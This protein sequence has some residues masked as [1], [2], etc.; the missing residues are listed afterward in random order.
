MAFGSI[1]YNTDLWLETESLPYLHEYYKAKLANLPYILRAAEH[2]TPIRSNK[3]PPSPLPPHAHTK[4]LR[5]DAISRLWSAIWDSAPASF[6][7]FSAWSFILHYLLTGASEKNKEETLQRGQDNV[8]GWVIGKTGFAH[9]RWGRNEFT[10]RHRCP[11][12]GL[13][14]H[15]KSV[16]CL[17]CAWGL[18]CTAAR[19]GT[20]A[21]WGGWEEIAAQV[22]SWKGSGPHSA[23]E[24][25]EQPGA[26]WQCCIMRS[27]VLLYSHHWFLYPTANSHAEES[28][29]SSDPQAL[30]KNRDQRAKSSELK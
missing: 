23:P 30:T 10:Q 1:L 5:L 7:L 14:W 19:Q 20:A 24:G 15:C 11:R 9:I 17:T 6:L 25:T 26:A 28:S 4:D 13:L 29:F 3:H 21:G 27:R 22:S 18:S 16:S 12:F 2:T 8:K